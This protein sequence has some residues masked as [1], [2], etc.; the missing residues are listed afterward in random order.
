M[1]YVVAHDPCCPPSYLFR[2]F[3]LLLCFLPHCFTILLFVHRILVL[4]LPSSS[5]F[6]ILTSISFPPYSHNPFP[7]LDS[8]LLVYSSPF[9]GNSRRFFW[10]GRVPVSYKVDS[11]S[12]ISKS[13]PGIGCY[14]Y[15][16]V[17]YVQRLG[18]CVRQENE[19]YPINASLRMMEFYGKV[20]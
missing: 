15:V 16:H 9:P 4:P 11:N 5:T 14:M 1:L 18:T 17:R 7:S 2:A 8:I 12:G 3:Y 19:E 20:A 6:T 10:M 13:E